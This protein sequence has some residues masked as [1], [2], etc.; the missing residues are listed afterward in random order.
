MKYCGNM[1]DYF[2]SDENG[3]YDKINQVNILRDK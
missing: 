3:E 2:D 1:T